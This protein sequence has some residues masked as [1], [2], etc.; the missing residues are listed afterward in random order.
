MYIGRPNPQAMPAYAASYASKAAECWT[1]DGGRKSP[2]GV[3]SRTS[4][5]KAKQ[6]LSFHCDCYFEHLNV[7]HFVAG[8]DPGL[9]RGDAVASLGEFY[10]SSHTCVGT[11]LSGINSY[12]DSLQC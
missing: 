12:Q 4:D 10:L 7:S 6:S 9:H 8:M 2:P 5:A 3:W 11:L 1:G